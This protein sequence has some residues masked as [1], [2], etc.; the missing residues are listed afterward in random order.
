MGDTTKGEAK[1]LIQLLWG[2]PRVVKSVSGSKNKDYERQIQL[3][4]L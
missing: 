1:L 2:N 3:K 4:K